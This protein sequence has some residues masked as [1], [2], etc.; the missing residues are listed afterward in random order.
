MTEGNRRRRAVYRNAHRQSHSSNMGDERRINIQ[1][2]EL[3]KKEKEIE[4]QLRGILDRF[5]HSDSALS[6]EFRDKKIELLGIYDEI[7]RLELE[8]DSAILKQ[9][10]RL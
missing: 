3:E 1:I 2:V 6:K 7:K 10:E 4:L 5:L 9:Q 8:R